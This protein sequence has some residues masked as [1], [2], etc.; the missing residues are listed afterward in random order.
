[1][2]A[3]AAPKRKLSV[4]KRIRQTKKRTK[5]NAFIEASLKTAI[6]KAR[7]S[8]TSKNNDKAAS[9]V[10]AAGRAMD[11]AVT[12]GVLHKN[13]ASRKKSRLMRQL[14]SLLKK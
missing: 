3:K 13:T 11:K 1:M 14:N 4:L 10:K 7:Q 9:L 5:R 2:A 6:K 12:K 8:L